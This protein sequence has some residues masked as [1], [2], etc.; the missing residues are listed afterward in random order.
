LTQPQR[1]TLRSRKR[2]NG[3]YDAPCTTTFW[4][5]LNKIDTDELDQ[6]IC[7]SFR[8]LQGEALQ[9]LLWIGK[10]CVAPSAKAPGTSSNDKGGHYLLTVK[11]YQLSLRKRIEQRLS[12][13]TF[14]L[15]SSHG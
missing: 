13:R 4:E 14:S 10:S 11:D 15:G 2:R 8:E 12:G 1:R 7:N 6:I 3:T 9:L 5:L